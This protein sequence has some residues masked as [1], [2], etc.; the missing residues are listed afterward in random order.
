MPASYVVGIDLGT[1]NS[2]VA[3]APTASETGLQVSD[4]PVPQ[5]QRP[6]QVAPQPLLPSC[7]YSPAEHE[8]AP[9]S[10]TLPWGEQTT[11][12]T[13]EFA[14]WQGARVPGRLVTS[15]KSWL[16]HPGVDRTA[17]IL[18]WGAPPDVP[19]IS[20]L[21]AST[22]LLRH[23][24]HAWDDA[25]PNAKLSA[26]D[27]VI[28]VPAS[29]D[30]VARA[31][32]VSAARE[33]GI[34]K[35]TLLEEPQA[36]FY[37]FVGRHTDDLQATL[38]G[39]RLVLVVDVG[40]GTSDFTLI[41]VASGEGNVVLKRVAVGDHLLL[42]GDNMD[43]AVARLAEEKLKASGQ[44]L[45]ASQWSQ[46][47]QA[48]RV[49][50]E[51]LLRE[52]P[53][54]QSAIAVASVGSRLVGGTVS[55]TLRRDE[56]LQ[57]VVEGFFPFCASAD[58]PKRG[59]R[60]ALQELGLPYATDPAI[61][62]HIAAFLGR[63]AEAGHSALHDGRAPEGI[64]GL[65]RPD[66]ILLNGGVFNSPVLA[67]RVVDVVSAWWPDQ[68]RI[69]LLHHDSLDLAVAR[70]AARYGLVRRGLGKRISGGAA[71]SLYV[72][73]SSKR[74]DDK[75]TA[76]CVI[77]RGTEEGEKHSIAQRTFSLTIG[78]PVQF[79]LYSTTAHRVDKAGDLIEVN[80]SF[81]TLPPLHT[82]FKAA[83]TKTRSLP[84]HLEAILTELGTL[85]LWCVAVTGGERWRLEFDL[86][87]SAAR[88]Q[89]TVTESMPAGFQE[90][91]RIIDRVF[92]PTPQAVDLKEV[93]QLGST[94]EQALGARESWRLP[95][96]REIWSTLFAGAG[97]RRR[98]PVHERIFLR[99]LG[100]SLRPGFGYPLDEW[101]CEQ[102][103]RLFA[104]SVNAHGDQSV[105]NEFWILWRR[106]AGGLN[107]SHHT[108]IWEYLKPHLARRVP[109]HPPKNA[110]R[111]KG[112]QPEGTDEMIRTAASLEHLE[113]SEK[114]LF[115]DW[116]ADRLKNPAKAG[117]GPWAWALGRLGARAPIY[118]SGHKTVPPDQ[119]SVW[120][121]VLLEAGLGKIEGAA[122]A[123][124]QLARLTGDRMRDLD[125]DI[126]ARATAAL[127]EYGAPA[128]SIEMLETVT[129]LSAEEE[130]KALGDTLPVGLRL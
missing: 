59:A 93:K 40:G 85:E 34:E 10:T 90:A 37:A 67:T 23:M 39:V 5:L 57:T 68:P 111:P 69:R 91:R 106:I 88:Q 70:G 97:K 17:A 74:G 66:A 87:G 125:D 26:Q 56:V 12:I 114:I 98:S 14:R 129:T 84:V 105:W 101:R 45:T 42:G 80:E 81:Q 36:A 19:K 8:L 2:A 108:A 128:R 41:Q 104:E 78:Q 112:I 53:P 49:S 89:E 92:G 11:W 61:T 25:H 107:E 126:R 109:R 71:Q 77:P 46:L 29:F 76:V 31:L 47:M 72:G 52:N 96:L 55:T 22:R 75:S 51:S 48:A 120:L 122:F 79:P 32:T 94:L 18:P 35:F 1:S 124:T 6:G 99:L 64:T 118:G 119:A 60:L 54:E 83:D 27:V 116:I 20:P 38:A 63:H 65:P 21:E 62:R 13:G 33:A 44:K 7:L 113:P 123:T 102:T 73:V 117:P 100:Y 110:A 28:T 24:A 121:E 30:E 4:F 50:K 86:R 43:A 103:F 127:R 3:F 115:G 95:L 9:G 130:S 82:V 58:T 15:A 16:C